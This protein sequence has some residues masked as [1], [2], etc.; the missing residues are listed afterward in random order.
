MRP[1]CAKLRGAVLA[2]VLFSGAGAPAFAGEGEASLIEGNG[3]LSLLRGGSL[4]PSVPDTERMVLSVQSGP[5]NHLMADQRL[6]SGGTLLLMHQIGT[7]NHAE[8][9]QSGSANAA[10]LT[11]LGNDNLATL[12]QIGGNNGL[13]QLQEGNGLSIAVTQYGGSQMIITQRNE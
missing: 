13:V 7:N 12:L 5:E 6:A 11:Q 3:I 2:A 8:I 10:S 1:I 4:V 9:V